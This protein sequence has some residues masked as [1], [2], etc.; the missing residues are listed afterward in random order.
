MV[1]CSNTI[2]KVNNVVLRFL[3]IINMFF[4]IVHNLYE[5]SPFVR[6]ATFFIIFSHYLR[7]LNMRAALILLFL[8]LEINSYFVIA[9][10]IMWLL[11]LSLR[12]KVVNFVHRSLL[13]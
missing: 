12:I 4:H 10:A 7:Y 13:I 6:I 11:G 8:I 3:V 5:E 2:I 1:Q 9:F